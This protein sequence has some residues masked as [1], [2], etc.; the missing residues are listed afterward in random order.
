MKKL[1]CKSWLIMTIALAFVFAPITI[2]LASHPIK[3]QAAYAKNGNGNGNGNANGHGKGL[4]ASADFE[5]SHYHGAKANKLGR[6]NAAHA[7]PNARLHA[8]PNSAVGQIAAY[9]LAATEAISSYKE[10]SMSYAELMETLA[11]ELAAAANKPVDEEVVAAVNN[12][13]G[14]EAPEESPEETI[15]ADVPSLQ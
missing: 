1:T 4:G 10:G 5:S 3:G 7:S 14:I 8:A 2:D 15:E 9:E 6:L 11:E 13:L 12:L